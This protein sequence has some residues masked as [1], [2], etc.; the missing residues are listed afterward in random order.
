MAMNSYITTDAREMREFMRTH[1]LEDQRRQM[2][3]FA[4]RMERAG[5]YTRACMSQSWT[6]LERMF[7]AA[8]MGQQ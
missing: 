4:A 3:L 1:N 7:Q 2:E 6:G 8:R 5:R